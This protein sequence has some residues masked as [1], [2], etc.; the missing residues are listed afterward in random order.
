MIELAPVDVDPFW[1]IPLMILGSILVMPVWT[2]DEL[3]PTTLEIF[4][5]TSPD[6]CDCM[7][8]SKLAILLV[9]IYV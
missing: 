7:M 2:T 9:L 1:I 6:N 3:P 5:S 8:F 4:D